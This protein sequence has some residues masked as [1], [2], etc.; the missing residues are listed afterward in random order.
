MKE[1]I[2]KKTV[3]VAILLLPYIALSQNSDF[4]NWLIYIGNNKLNSK[5][6][7]HNEVQY[8]NYNTIGDLE[9]LLIRT[10]LGYTFNDKKNNVLL[11]YGYILSENYISNSDNK[12]TIN[13]HR[14]FQQFTT[15]QTFGKV[16]LGHRYRF[17]QRFVESNFK[18]RLRYFL[19]LNIPINIMENNKYYL[20]AYNEIFLNTKTSVFDRNRLYGGIGYNINRA[21]R[22]EVGYMNQFFERSNRDQLNIITFVNF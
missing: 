16:K 8:R 12:A 1:S 7:I 13:E 3:L 4:G 15:T 17:E 18:M 9:Q 14:I 5:W 20:S 11:G 21:I 2:I 6:N 10:G 19:S 22:I